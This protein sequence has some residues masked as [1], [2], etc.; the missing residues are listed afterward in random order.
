[1]S[2]CT[3]CAMCERRHATRTYVFPVCRPCKDGL[4]AT[5]RHLRAMEADDPELADLGARVETAWDRLRPTTT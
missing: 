4:E 1:M 5:E 3:M 2:A